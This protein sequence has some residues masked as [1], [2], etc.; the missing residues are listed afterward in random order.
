MGRAFAAAL[1]ALAI[2]AVAAVGAPARTAAAC[3]VGQQRPLG[4]GRVAYGAYVGSR[5]VAYRSPGRRAVATFGSLNVN[6]YPTVFGVLGEVVGRGCRPAWYRVQLPV[7]PNGTTGYVPA[8]AVRLEAVRT[9][10]VVE[11]SR[12]SLTLFRDGRPVLKTR[13]AVGTDATPTPTGRFYVNQRLRPSDPR[14]PYGP[15]ALGISAFSDVLTGWAQGGPIGIHG[16]NEPWLLGRAVTHGC[17]R[18]ANAPMERLF[19]LTPAGTPVTVR[20]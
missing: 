5:A 4:N 10:V 17:I 9:R 2:A 20:R 18:V 1:C 8:S 14:G 6:G 13:I 15:A 19:R 3:R 7:R 12:R 16:T 11:L